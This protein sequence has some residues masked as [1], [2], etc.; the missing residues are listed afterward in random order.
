MCKYVKTGPGV[1]QSV[2]AGQLE[3]R[4]PAG[5]RNFSLRHSVHTVSGTHRD[6]YQMDTGAP[7]P[8]IKLDH[9]P[10]SSATVKNT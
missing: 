1:A 2:R 8:R 4:F 10:P 9:S 7:F 3:V 5:V 6:S